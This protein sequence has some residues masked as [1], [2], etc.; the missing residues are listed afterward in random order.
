MKESQEQAAE[1][2]G[3]EVEPA[4]A[5]GLADPITGPAVVSTWLQIY[6]HRLLPKEQ[7]T[8]KWSSLQGGRTVSDRER[9]DPWETFNGSTVQVATVFQLHPRCLFRVLTSSIFHH[10]HIRAT[11]TI[12]LI[13]WNRNCQEHTGTVNLKEDEICSSS[14]RSQG[15]EEQVDRGGTLWKRLVFAHSD[16]HSKRE[17]STLRGRDGMGGLS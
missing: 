1:K 15:P 10:I 13:C 2:K 6:L 5:L 14:Q 16:K 17:E 4:A 3:E 8:D 9:L 12:F 7:H 11:G